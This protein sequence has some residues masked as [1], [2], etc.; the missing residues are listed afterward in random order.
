MKLTGFDCIFTPR[1]LSHSAK[2]QLIGEWFKLLTGKMPRLLPILLFTVVLPVAGA[3]PTVPTGLVSSA[4]TATSFT[5]KWTASS[6]GTGGIA[7]YDVYSNGVFV[8]SPT[9]TT[10]A[11]SG[12]APLT[13][14]S[15]TVDARDTAGNVSPASAALPVTTV[16]DT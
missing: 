12:L 11:V 10:L 4:I 14:Y 9:T 15:M 7:A 8:G 3:A 6:G 13:G 1:S 2:R 16:A 5:L